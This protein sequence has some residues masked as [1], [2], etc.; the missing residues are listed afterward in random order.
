MFANKYSSRAERYQCICSYCCLRLTRAYLR[1]GKFSF[2]TCRFQYCTYI[3]IYIF[4]CSIIKIPSTLFQCKLVLLLTVQS[5]PT[6]VV[7]TATIR[8][9]NIFPH[10]AVYVI[11][12]MQV[13]R[14]LLPLYIQC[15]RCLNLS[16]IFVISQNKQYFIVCLSVI[17]NF[18]HYS[19]KSIC[20]GIRHYRY[21]KRMHFKFLISIGIRLGKFHAPSIDILL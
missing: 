14:Y 2:A 10:R 19:T 15:H 5:V 12:Y 17:V 20:I 13:S 7:G 11:Y 16:I 1:H 9:S 4:S 8:Y 18:A 21:Q 6:Q 3:P